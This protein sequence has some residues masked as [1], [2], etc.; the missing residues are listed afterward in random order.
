MTQH[1]Q[2]LRHWRVAFLVWLIV[3]TIATH[4]PQDPPI[5]NPTIESPDKLLHFVCFGMLAFLFMSTRWVR[6]VLLSWVVV[7][8]WTVL[9]EVTQDLLPLNRAF[10][11]GDL[12]AGE[13][14]VFAAYVWQGALQK[15][16]LQELEQHVDGVLANWKNWLYLAFVSAFTVVFAT[17]AFWFLFRGMTDQQQSEPAFTTGILVGMIATLT[18]FCT[19]GNIKLNIFK[20]KKNMVLLLVATMGIPAMIASFVPYTFVDPWVLSLFAS[21]LGARVF[22]NMAT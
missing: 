20:H 6:H 5:E 1:D 9:D 17:I 18:L 19:L 16:N 15:S 22:W 11:Q 3:L 8:L 13:L 10:S 14:G 7:A 12:I 21:V 4:L 2:V